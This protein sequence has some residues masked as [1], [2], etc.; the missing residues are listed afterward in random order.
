MKKRGRFSKSD[1]G[2]LEQTQ[3]TQERV[4]LSSKGGREKCSINEFRGES[5]SPFIAKSQIIT[6]VQKKKKEKRKFHSITG[7][8]KG[9]EPSRNSRRNAASRG[10]KKRKTKPPEN[11]RAKK[12]AEWE[13]SSSND[14]GKR[15][16]LLERGEFV[17]E[18]RDRLRIKGVPFS[19]EKK[20]PQQRKN[21]SIHFRRR[22]KK[23]GRAMSIKGGGEKRKPLPNLDSKRRASVPR[24]EKKKNIFIWLQKK[25]RWLLSGGTEVTAL[26]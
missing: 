22:G 24:G 19:N 10:K 20:N 8:E 23:K 1:P 17:S 2:Q 4:T 21:D 3:P 13:G 11:E 18:E 7:K 25:E 15:G 14:G 6:F 5:Q 12:I 26:W 16:P 9:D